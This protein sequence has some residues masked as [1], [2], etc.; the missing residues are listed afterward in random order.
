V[1]NFCEHGNELSG[2]IKGGEFLYKV[3]INVSRRAVLSPSIHPSI[4][5]SYLFSTI[6]DSTSKLIVFLSVV[7]E[8]YLNVRFFH[9]FNYL[10]TLY[11][12]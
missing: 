1:A 4:H 3:T 10:T 12:V 11:E 2:P 8:S 9:L 6:F 7:H 5:P